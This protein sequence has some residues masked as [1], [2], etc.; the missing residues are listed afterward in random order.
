LKRVLAESEDL[1]LVGSVPKLGEAYEAV[2]RL[3]PNVALIDLSAGL[4][5]ALRLVGSLK[6]ASANLHTILW[7]VDLPEFEAFRALQL[8]VHGILRKTRPIETLVDCV[9]EVAGGKV[10]MEDSDNVTEFFHR[11]EVSRLTARERQVVELVC[12]GMKNSQ[13]AENLKITPGTVKVHL[14]H[15][16]EKTGLKDRLALAVHGR[17]LSGTEL[18]PTPQVSAAGN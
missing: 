8:G 4:T 12:R 17:K 18:A 6:S 10:W 1:E 9:R 15:I 16:F 11:Q 5:S 3:Q 2:N 13:I 7:V 14:M